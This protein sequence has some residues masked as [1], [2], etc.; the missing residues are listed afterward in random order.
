MR[1][2]GPLPATECD[3]GKTHHHTQAPPTRSSGARHICHMLTNA[4]K[5]NN[6][7]AKR[8]KSLF[9][10]IPSVNYKGPNAKL[11][12]ITFQYLTRVLIINMHPETR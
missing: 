10:A 5:I 7:D 12:H 11:Q 1:G 3:S 8:N 6:R 9:S 2:C 4:P